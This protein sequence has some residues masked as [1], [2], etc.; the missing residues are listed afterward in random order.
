MKKFYFFKVVRETNAQNQL[1]TVAYPLPGQVTNRYYSASSNVPV[2]ED[3]KVQFCSTENH[4][5]VQ[6]SAGVIIGVMLESNR[7]RDLF[8]ATYSRNGNNFYR[9][10]NEV[11]YVEDPQL[12]RPCPD[13]ITPADEEMMTAYRALVPAGAPG[14]TA[15][16]QAQAAT[17]PSA[18]TYTPQPEPAATAHGTG[19][20]PAAVLEQ[21]NDELER[22]EDILSQRYSGNILEQLLQISQL[23]DR[24]RL[25]V[26]KFTFFKQNG[27][28]RVAYGTRRSNLIPGE[29]RESNRHS[30]GAHFYYFDIQR[31]DWRNFCVED[32]KNLELNFLATEPNGIEA[33]RQ[34]PV[35][36]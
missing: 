10:D 31:Q 3:I 29:R 22:I 23:R 24:M 34:I 17:A 12:G 15:A 32:F 2:H 36:E 11:R 4:K 25:G 1:R 13:F 5:V 28:E 20:Q 19:S 7:A 6:L 16:T 9:I 30:D 18:P 35:E 33:I 21:P 26:A 27:Q 14:E 8:L